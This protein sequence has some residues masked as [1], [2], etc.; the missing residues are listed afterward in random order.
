[1]MVNEAYRSAEKVHG[2]AWAK[3]EAA[4]EASGDACPERPVHNRPE[5]CSCRKAGRSVGADRLWGRIEARCANRAVSANRSAELLVLAAGRHHEIGRP[6]R[7]IRTRMTTLTAVHTGMRELK[8]VS[9][10]KPSCARSLAPL[11]V[12][13]ERGISD[14]SYAQRPKIIAE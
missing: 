1:M 9:P 6:T 2:R 3:W 7:N 13:T 12:P 8:R 4:D 5:R 11:A 14:L 10:T